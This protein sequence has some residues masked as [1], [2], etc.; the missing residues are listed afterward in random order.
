MFRRE[1]QQ[2]E[3]DNEL[4]NKNTPV[5]ERDEEDK[6]EGYIKLSK[7]LRIE[8]LTLTSSRQT[9]RPFLLLVVQGFSNILQLQLNTGMG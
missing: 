7:P 4:A 1:L 9:T 5:E 6:A 3:K 2:A 8:H